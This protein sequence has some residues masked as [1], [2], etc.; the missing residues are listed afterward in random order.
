MHIRKDSA[1]FTKKFVRAFLENGRL[2]FNGY[3]SYHRL[4]ISRTASHSEL[5]H[6]IVRF[7]TS[8]SDSPT[9]EVREIRDTVC[10]LCQNADAFGEIRE[11]EESLESNLTKTLLGKLADEATDKHLLLVSSLHE[12]LRL[13][14]NTA[15]V[16]F[17][18][19]FTQN[20]HSIPRSEL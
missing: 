19:M 4:F 10:L 15:E 17:V 11:Y 7:F 9:I 18:L 5:N 3:L 20:P 6:Y 8:G 14:A 12:A 2:T 1:S 16:I 13:S